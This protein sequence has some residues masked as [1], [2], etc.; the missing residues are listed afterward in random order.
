MRARFAPNTVETTF[1]YNDQTKAKAY[2]AFPIKQQTMHIEYWLDMLSEAGFKESD[3]PT[4]W[5]EYWSFWCEKVQP[6]SR[7]QSGK[8]TFGIGMPMGVDSSDSFYSFLT[9][10]DAYNVE[11]VNDSG[12]LLVDDPKVKAGLVGGADRLHHAL[13]QGLHAAIVD[14]LEGSGQQRR[15]PQ[16]DD[17][18]DA[19]RDHL[20]RRQVAR[21]HEQRRRSRPS[22][23]RKPRRTTRSASAQPAC[24]T[25]PTAARWSTA[26]R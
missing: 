19:Q 9:F 18:D 1:L 14:Q 23:A 7:K 3:I 24:R 6:A 2:Y 16:Q 22:S 5:K 17:R 13:P 25:S 15:L 4:N 20:D 12:K 21:R 26:P 8:R 11:L 10:V